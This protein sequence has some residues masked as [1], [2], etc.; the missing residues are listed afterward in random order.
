MAQMRPAKIVVVGGGFGG[1]FT[2]LELDGLS[3]VTLITSDDHFTFSPMLYEYLSGEVEAWHVAPYYK[4]LV[5]DKMR[6][7][8]G[9]VD[10]IDFDTHQVHVNNRE[11]PLEYDALVLAIGG[12]SNY[13]NVPGAMNYAL[14]FR[15]I[16]HA[17]ELRRRMIM[18]LD[19]IAPDATPEEVRDKLT[20][21]IVGGG[22]SGVEL[23]TKMGDLLR[24]AFK[25][26]NLPG[27]A[28]L[29]LIEQNEQVVPGMGDEL[30]RYVIE[31]LQKSGVEVHTKATVAEVK[32][33]SLVFEQDNQ[34]TEV[35]TVAVVWT[36]GV[37]VS[38]LAEKLDLAKDEKNL[39]LIEPTMQVQG[40]PEVFALG[41]SAK[42][43]NVP[44]SLPGTAQLAFQESSL[45]AANIKAFLSG[46]KL[47]TKEFQELG[48]ALSLGT[49][50]AAVLVGDH[51]FGGALAREARYT[52]YTSR[53][54]TWHHRLR[55]G[56][57]WFFEGTQPRPLQ[58]SRF[59]L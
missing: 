57:S 36:A 11:Q 7:V 33:H 20:F 54:P 55:V 48:E 47:K 27:T 25:Q 31:A 59:N 23:A 12:V 52:L 49:K 39:I 46:Q 19:Q 24:E 51:A 3:D 16:A 29:L 17:D 42:L 40:R 9:E 58:A 30:R 5:G 18:A 37:R 28:R 34:Q 14:P 1:L 15:K 22:A 13:Y 32:P 10:R 21:A 35:P 53:L 56:A 45:T 6:V 4:D 8:R 41:D 26:R 43:A 2:A 38:P 50:N 44:P